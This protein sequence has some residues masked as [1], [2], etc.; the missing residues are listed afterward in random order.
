M[1][2]T[3]RVLDPAAGAGILLCALVE[4]LAA[5]RQAPRRIELVAYEI[6][7][8]L[9]NVLMDVLNR[10]QGW[11]AKRG[12]AVSARVVCKDFVLEHAEA[13]RNVEGFLPLLPE[14]KAFD[15]VIANP[16]YFKL[17]K[18]DPR[19]KAAA[20]VVHGQPNIYGLFMAVGAALLRQG[21]ELV[22]ITPR[23]FASGPYFRL[24]RERFFECIRP[25]LVHVFGSRRDPFNR[26]AVLQENVILKGVRQDS[27]LRGSP[28]GMMTISSSDGVTDLDRSGY[29]EVRID[30][31]LDMA[32]REKVLRLPISDAEDDLTRLVDSW[33]GS[34]R[35]YGLQI[36]T[37]PVVPFRATS[38]IDKDGNVPGSHVPLLWMN[39]VQLMQVTW[40]IGRHKPEYIK[41]GTEARSVLVPNRNY[42]LLRRFSAK[43]E[44]R[45]LVAGPYLA[46]SGTTSMIGLENHLNYIYR[47]G[48]T[49]TE[50]ET[51]GLAALFS[52]SLLDMYFRISNGNTQ[53][54]A[55]ELRTMPLPA[56][57]VI[58]AI[59]QQARTLDGDLP[60]INA[61]VI[62]FAGLNEGNARKIA[63]G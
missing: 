27:W 63:Y 17:N 24:F 36:S 6:D 32:S 52:S 38:L 5:R 51:F 54:S 14:G 42:V 21:G 23:S 12:I 31:V 33:P 57:S 59:G 10:L 15:V 34:L 13:L 30:S 40:P 16:P 4:S 9:A 62:Q 39:H 45:R 1:G 25:E 44:E 61:M 56:S 37:G 7:P 22:F 35:A 2:N 20:A 48:G 11:A 50:D 3:V 55:T 19:A 41:S 58:S 18:A 49:L 26:D 53:V 46:S 60:G 43:E 28:D 47:P 29:H 8:H